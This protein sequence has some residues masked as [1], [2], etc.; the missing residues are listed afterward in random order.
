M[1]SVYVLIPILMF[2]SAAVLSGCKDDPGGPPPRYHTEENA[3]IWTD[4]TDS[5]VP[6]VRRLDGNKIEVRV[7]FSPTLNPLHYVEAIVLMKGEKKVIA[8]KKFKP[9]VSIPV[10]EFE[11]PDSDPDYWVISKCNLHDMWK[12]EIK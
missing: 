9:S 3:G 7:T 5:H 8:E 10:A 4:I 2:I 11:L 6:Q 12:A 1:K